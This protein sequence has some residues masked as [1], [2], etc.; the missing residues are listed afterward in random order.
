M[1]Y[2]VH[3]PRLQ[4]LLTSSFLYVL[5]LLSYSCN[6]AVEANK[7]SDF[8]VN[9]ES[10]KAFTKTLTK[11]LDAVGQKNLAMLKS[12]LSPNDNMQL[13]L[14]GE[15]IKR[16]NQAFLNFHKEWFKDETWTFESK[17]LNSKVGRELGFAITEVIYREPERNGK[18]YFNRMIV[19]YNLE[20]VEGQWYVLTDH[21]SSVEKS[22]DKSS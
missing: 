2:S 3:Y 17:I 7:L 8:E 19:S 1:N 14:P 18:P 21:A 12:T 5:M 10:K 22:T 13:I 20:K 16:T 6:Q 4:V 15:E 9:E 11:H